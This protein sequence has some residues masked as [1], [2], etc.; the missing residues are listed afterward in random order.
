MPSWYVNVT[1][2]PQI[3]VWWMT[4]CHDTWGCIQCLTATVTRGKLLGGGLPLLT[5]EACMCLS[6]SFIL[7]RRGSLLLSPG[8]V[9]Q[10]RDS[11]ISLS[12]PH[13]F[14]SRAIW[15]AFVK[16]ILISYQKEITSVA[17]HYLQ[18][19]V[20]TQSLPLSPTSH[21]YHFWSFSSRQDTELINMESAGGLI[22]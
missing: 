20:Q 19:Q 15:L 11:C 17:A 21:H 2:L 16:E 5:G 3:L 12:S 18:G 14:F 1:A 22:R 4:S 10:L 7:L 9:K 8:W 6:S 13:F